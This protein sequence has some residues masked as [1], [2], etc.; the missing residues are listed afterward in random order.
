MA[1]METQAVAE[2]VP[3]LVVAREV[4]DRGGHRHHPGTRVIPASIKHYLSNQP[5]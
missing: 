2:A 5:Y 1:A 4:D 3:Q